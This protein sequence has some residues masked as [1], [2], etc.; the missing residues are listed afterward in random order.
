MSSLTEALL[1]QLG[2]GGLESLG[3]AIGSN[4]QATKTA[5][6]AALPM[7]FAALSKNAASNDGASALASALDRDHDG[8]VLDGL[9]SAFTPERKA[10]GDSIL[11]HVLGGSRTQAE[12]GIAQASGLDATQA[13]AMLAKMAPLVMGALGKTKRSQGLDA[14]GITDL[15]KGESGHAQ[16]QLGGLA[17][18]LDRDGDGSIADDLLGGLGKSLFGRG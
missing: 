18:L 2:D 14:G 5:A 4:P 1:G 9:T 10:E 13:S 7:L 8:S 3:R 16:K 17:S 6:A 15:L 12:A 11:K